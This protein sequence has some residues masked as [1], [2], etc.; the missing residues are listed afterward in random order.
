MDELRQ[1][2]ER[3]RAKR[4]IDA[5]QAAAILADAAGRPEGSDAG[6][7]AAGAWLKRRRLGE[8]LGYVGAVCAVTAG[9]LVAGQEWVRLG[10]GARSMLLLVAVAVLA[11]SGW[12]ANQQ[13]A[14][15]VRRLGAVLWFLAVAAV[16]GF[17]GVVADQVLHQSHGVAGVTAWLAATVVGVLFWRLRV[18][19]LQQVAAFVSLFATVTA[20]A[21]VI[22]PARQGWGGGA[23]WA[24]GVIWLLL[25]SRRLLPP[26]RTAEVLGALA[27]LVGAET[28]RTAELRSWGLALGLLSAAALVGAGTATRRTVLLGVGAV[29]LFVFLFDAVTTWFGRGATVPLALLAAGG[30]LLLVAVLTSRTRSSHAAQDRPGGAPG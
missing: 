22:A 17:A 16:A 23:V 30:A 29:G 12:W 27:M 3:W 28:M 11:A 21:G 25:G 18:S 20:L 13:R 7:G 24:V 10:P 5:E 26:A 4:L 9:L 8:A 19:S 1:Q 15:S 2:V 14:A 6:G